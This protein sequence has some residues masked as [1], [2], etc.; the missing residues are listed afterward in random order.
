[1]KSDMNSTDQAARRKRVNLLKK[2]IIVFIFAILMVPILLCVILSSRLHNMEKDMQE[3]QSLL[4]E[5]ALERECDTETESETSALQ[6]ES[7]FENL[8]EQ[9]SDVALPE[10]SGDGNVQTP[11]TEVSSNPDMQA[12]QN[13]DA[14]AE[15][16]D[17][18]EK[19]RK[20]YLTFDDGPSSETG[21]ILD[22]LATYDVKAT[23]FVVGKTDEDSQALYR[24]I[25]EEG[26]TLGMHSYSHVYDDIYRSVEGFAGDLGKLQGYLYDVTGVTS[27]IYRFPG[28]SSNRVSKSDMQVF[29]KWLDEQGIEYY[30]WNISSGDANPVRLTAQQVLEN[31]TKDLEKYKNAI[32]LLHD[33]PSKKT[34]VEAL[35]ALIEQILEMEDT[36]I[37]PITEDT[38]PVQHITN[39]EETED[40]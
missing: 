10:L 20:V 19:L 31:C 13:T 39:K 15:T 35:P 21:Q 27:K 26:H 23:F 14:V 6:D 25:V 11:E 22:I 4:R 12:E 34:T 36:V 5:I 28:G 38:R 37:L 16:T 18:E 2:L 29:I 9:M 24:R 8:Q 32:I 30:D 40:E 3:I 17:R 7:A 33:A 1:M